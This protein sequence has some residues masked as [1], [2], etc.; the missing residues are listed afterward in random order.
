MFSEMAIDVP[1]DNML[2]GLDINDN[3][4]FDV[5]GVQI[6]HKKYTQNADD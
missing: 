1:T 4:I 2:A 6:L 3:L 5:L